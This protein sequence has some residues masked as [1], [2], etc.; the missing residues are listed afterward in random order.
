MIPEPR[1]TSL[2]IAIKTAESVY[3]NKQK[4]L[5][6]IY[7]EQAHKTA[8]TELVADVDNI[9]FITNLPEKLQE[10]WQEKLDKRA[11]SLKKERDIFNEYDPIL[12]SGLKQ[13]IRETPDKV[14]YM[15]IVDSVGNGLTPAYAQELFELQDKMQ[16]KDNPLNQSHIKRAHDRIN[17]LQNAQL[18]VKGIEPPTAKS[19]P[20]ETIR[21]M[22]VFDEMHDAID[23]NTDLKPVEMRQYTEEMVRPVA[24]EAGKGF[25]EVF[26]GALGWQPTTYGFAL[27]ATYMERERLLR[28][29]PMNRSDFETKFKN[30]Y[31]VDPDTANKYWDRWEDE[32]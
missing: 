6:D 22:N 17:D 1:Q 4:S 3:E 2:R 29:R 21:Y 11:A 23:R 28:T 13:T 24:E 18:T 15:D 5:T 14:D 9:A 30:L 26:R 32:W 7:T 27:G 10:F 12:F 16:L 19:T 8:V 25:W 31:K 20:E